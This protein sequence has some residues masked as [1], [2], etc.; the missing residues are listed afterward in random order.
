MTVK[1]YD[2]KNIFIYLIAENKY[3]YKQFK[4]YLLYIFIK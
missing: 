1:I 4:P 2:C 3:I